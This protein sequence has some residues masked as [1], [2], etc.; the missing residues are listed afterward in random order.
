[1]KRRY[2]LITPFKKTLRNVTNSTQQMLHKHH[3]TSIYLVN[4]Y[5]SLPTATSL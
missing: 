1:M 3:E 4:Y 2:L 5:K